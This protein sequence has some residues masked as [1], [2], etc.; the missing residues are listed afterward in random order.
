MPIEFLEGPA[1]RPIPVQRIR[2]VYVRVP[3]DKLERVQVEGEVYVSH[4]ETCTSP[5]AFT[6]RRGA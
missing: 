5:E 4:F 1:G 6:R 2:T 3:G